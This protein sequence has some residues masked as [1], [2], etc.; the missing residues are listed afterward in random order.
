MIQWTPGAGAE[1]PENPRWWPL[2]HKTI[3]A[4]KKVY[5]GWFRQPRQALLALK[6]E[7]GSKLKQFLISLAVSSRAEAEELLRLASD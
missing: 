6:R 3:D 2:Y 4:G 7:F 5:I 1:G